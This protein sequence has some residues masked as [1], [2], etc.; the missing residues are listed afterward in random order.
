MIPCWGGRRRALKLVLL[1]SPIIFLSV[2]ATTVTVYVNNYADHAGAYL[3][4]YFEN[5]NPPMTGCSSPCFG[6]DTQTAIPNPT[7]GTIAL[8]SSASG[9]WSSGSSFTI[10]ATTSKTNDVIVL[11]I[12]TASSITVSSVSD[13]LSE[14]TWQSS[15]RASF[16]SC[17]GTQ[18]TTETEW[19][20]IAPTTISSD[21][22]TIY[23]S[24]TPTSA[25]G[26]EFSVK[27]ANTGSPFDTN[28]SVPKD[29]VSACTS[30]TS[31]PT[32]SGI[33]TN[34]QNDFVF[35]LSG[36]YTSVTESVG[37][38]GSSTATKIKTVAATGHSAGAEYAIVSSAQSGVSCSFGTA[39][40]YWGVLCDAIVQGS[41]S[42][43]LPAGSSM[44]LWS[45]QF[46]AQTSISSGSLSFQLMADA[47]PP[48]L[49]G[50]ASGT[51]SSGSSFTIH[52][53]NTSSSNDVIVLSIVTSDGAT[54][55]TVTS[56]SD[57]QTKIA[58]QSSARSAASYCSSPE[59]EYLTE[60]Y[61]I[62]SSAL[63]S[64]TINVGLSTTPLSASGIAFGI[65]GAD[66][67]TPFDPYSTLPRTNTAC[68]ATSSTPSVG[69]VYTDADTD[70]VFGLFGGYTAVN[71][72][73]GTIGTPTASVIRS[74]S[75]TGINNAAEYT[76]ITQSLSSATCKYGT[77]STYW[78]I[79][80]DAVMPAR[81]T[82]TVSY[83]TTNSAGTLYSTMI[84]NSP[85]TLTGIYAPI[86]ITSS[87]GTVPA[88]GY[89]LVIITASSSAL[90]VYWGYGNPTFFQIEFNAQS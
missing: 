2:A 8:D 75:G 21:I 22:I 44:Y 24:G 47:P 40:T 25:S 51:W 87:S 23:L 65:S 64:D 38:I 18:M 71:Q 34:N 50:N 66:T 35:A 20:G 85:G 41:G 81:Q 17:S 46:G 32:V 78:K 53:L 83:E 26:I 42:F 57:S 55:V 14:V 15:A 90:T 52:S 69:S 72:T 70:F 30:T 31:V 76:T 88:S 29:A 79:L 84:S 45:P 61:G 68:S 60:W 11:W 33:S 59:K 73:A 58:W 36:G 4:P 12:V 39:T 82:L 27:G 10:N 19:Y 86:S 37:T 49:D 62:A 89:V 67:V 80:C 7:L 48:S 5:T 63:S 77:S 3:Q 43:T 13:S 6:V 56:V 54:A 74:I 16:T 28:P 9:T 1:I